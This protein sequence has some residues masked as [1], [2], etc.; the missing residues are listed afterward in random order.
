MAESPT[1]RR[2]VLWRVALLV[3][4]GGCAPRA[5]RAVPR[6]GPRAGPAA[7]KVPEL[8]EGAELRDYLV[9]AA[10]RNPGL[11]AAFYRWRAAAER[12]PQAR[13]L[14][15]AKLTYGYFVREVETRVGPQE[16]RVG[17]MQ[18]FPW[19]GT[20]RLRGDVAA[21]QAA[22]Q[23][24]LYD[25]EE[26]RLFYRVRRAYHDY[27][28]LGRAIGIGGENIEL[29]RNLEAVVR[30]R[31]AAG[32]AGHPS[33][34]Q[35]H[36]ELGKLED[37]LKSLQDLRPA[38]AAKLNA[39]LG[40]DAATPVPWPRPAPKEAEPLD[41]DR[42]AAALATDNPELEAS[43]ER[44]RAA[45]AARKLARLKARPDFGLGLSYTV[46]GRRTD[47]NPADNGRDPLFLMLDVSLPIW[48]ARN[49]AA[50]RE[51][52]A[53]RA[54]AQLARAD[55]LH[56]L[57][58]ALRTALYHHRD[59]RRKVGLFRDTLIPKIQQALTASQAAFAAGKGSF[60][61]IIDSERTLLE[62]RLMG[63]RARA[64]QAVSLAELEM[65]AGRTL[66]KRSERKVSK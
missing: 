49:R 62:F 43:R 27:A 34:I 60:L 10:L 20:L 22:V 2:S 7:E 48:A 57:S 11:E 28:Y 13:S 61:D 44:I 30:I 64:D 52:E 50:V 33:L 31:Y 3:A 54:A 59:A 58:A 51:A 16:H 63:E 1:G 5:E 42:L 14:P 21:G 26:L 53:R 8:G 65:L 56:E 47:A 23:R 15:D 55:K 41:E 40:R 39:A 29:V 9:Y 18:G 35:T 38:L 32:A 66:R 25:A 46:T 36:V 4:L 24:R 37:R 45:E 19:P 17:I 12:I 6:E